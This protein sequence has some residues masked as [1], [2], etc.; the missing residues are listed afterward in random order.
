MLDRD[1]RAVCVMGMPEDA[2][3]RQNRRD[4][5]AILALD[6]VTAALA[7]LIKVRPSNWADG[8]DPQ[9]TDAWKLAAA[10]LAKSEGKA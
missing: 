4:A 10:A 9:Q 1:G 8:D 3:T 2:P 5:Q 6:D 7:A